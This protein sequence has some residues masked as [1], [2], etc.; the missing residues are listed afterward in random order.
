MITLVL[1]MTF[2]RIIIKTIYSEF[3][4]RKKEKRNKKEQ[5]KKEY[6]VHK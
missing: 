3:K 1:P 6:Y 2:Y 4:I 5:K